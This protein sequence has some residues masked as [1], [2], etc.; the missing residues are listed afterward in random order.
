MKKKVFKEYGISYPPIRG[1][2]EVD[3]FIPI[4]LGGSNDIKNLWPELAEPRPGFNEKDTVEEYLHNQVCS[5][6]I[7]LEK[8]QELIRQDWLVVYQQYQRE[9]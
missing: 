5:D 1:A 6:V 8:A 2:Y 9:H 3:H 7:S 4:E